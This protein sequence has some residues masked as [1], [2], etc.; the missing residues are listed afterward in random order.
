LHNKTILIAAGG[1][2][3]HLYPA[4]AVAEEIRREEPETKIIFV[5]TRDRIE[6]KEVPREGFPFVPITIHAPRKSLVSLITFPWKFALA[7]LAC[8][9]LV[10]KEKPSAFLGAGAYLSVPAG[11]AAWAFHVPIALLEIN[12]VPGSSNKF[13][14]LLA[15]KLFL[16]YREAAATFPKRLSGTVTVCGTPVRW[17]GD[18]SAA[19]DAASALKEEARLSFGLEASRT[20]IL[21][22]GGSL[23]AGPIN[24]ALRISARS[25]AEQGY[26]VLWQTGRSAN[27][28]EF[29]QE[30]SDI[31][32]VR[33][34]E[35]IYDMEG[36]YRAA[37]LVICRAGASSLAELA[38]LGKPAVLVPWSGAMANHQER[39][40][41]AFEQDGSAVV[42][43]DREVA[44]KLPETVIGLL[45][46][47]ERLHA[48]AEA[49]KQRDNPDAARQ[50]AQ[51]L[52]TTSS[53]G[54]SRK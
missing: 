52:I 7:I 26:N 15:N 28:T 18:R 6:S 51:W 38:R 36:A 5:G 31:A 44:N 21:A 9:K 2:G 13:L 27:V 42:L 41:R 4:L 20:T 11:I 22:F 10:A 34:M 17:M 48:M 23:G 1:T 50:V 53:A 40:A 46:D 43:T 39:N 33:V 32:N 54:N 24:Q 49:M 19:R 29:Q 35:Y 3:G 25:F 16:A 45:N 12:S 47:S 14:A 30:F 8:M 37:D